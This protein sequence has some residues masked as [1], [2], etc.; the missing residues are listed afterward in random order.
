M[1]RTRAA[2]RL[3]ALISILTL[4]P[5]LGTG[6]ASGTSGRMRRPCENAADGEHPNAGCHLAQPFGRDDGTFPFR[7]T[8]EFT[9]A[10]GSY[11][12]ALK[13]NSGTGADEEA[14]LFWKSSCDAGFASACLHLGGM[15]QYGF[16]G[17]QDQEQANAAY[18][19]ACELGFEQ[20]CEM[21]VE[22]ASGAD[23]EEQP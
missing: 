13:G 6:C 21:P 22:D 2:L 17:P 19:R 15:W 4:I 3:S 7:S 10:Q 11:L 18:R 14:R 5:I 20:A 16:G 12:E 23:A 9:R 8:S 1:L